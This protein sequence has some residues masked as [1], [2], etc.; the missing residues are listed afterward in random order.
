MSTTANY[1]S[2]PK[3]SGAQIATANTGRDGTGTLGTVYTAGTNGSRIDSLDIQATGTTTAGMIRFF[4]SIDTGTTKRLIGEVPVLAITAAATTPCFQTVLTSQNASFMQNG[5][6]LDIESI[7][8][9]N[10]V[11]LDS[12]SYEIDMGVTRSFAAEEITITI[13]TSYPVTDNVRQ[14]LIENFIRNPTNNYWKEVK[15]EIKSKRDA[16]TS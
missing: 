11:D 16:V 4:I 14:L 3:N 10:P 8:G 1:A 5:L 12:T 15:K 6:S 2:T 9:I 13:D 7:I